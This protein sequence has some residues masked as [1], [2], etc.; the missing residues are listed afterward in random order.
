MM[1]SRRLQ[2]NVRDALCLRPTFLKSVF[3]RHERVVETEEQGGREKKRIDAE[4]GI[5]TAIEWRLWMVDHQ[6]R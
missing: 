6:G 3:R 5:V 1:N 2:K 4:F